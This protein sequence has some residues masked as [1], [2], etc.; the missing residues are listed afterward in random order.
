[1]SV[2]SSSEKTQATKVLDFWKIAAIVILLLAI[3]TRFYALGDRAVSHDE[4][5]HAK[6]SWNLYTGQGFRHDPLMHGPLLFEVTA[7]LYALFGVSDFTARIYAAALGVALV[8][9]PWLFQK[10]LG[11]RGALFAS[12]MLLIS[13]AITYY[14][15][16]TR[17]D[18][19]V[20]LWSTLLLWT[21]LQYL[22]T[23][24]T[25]WLY[26]M[27]A[28]FPLMYASKENAYIYTAIF[29]VLLALPFLWQVMRTRWA[30]P[31]FSAVLAVVVIIAL[32][33]G[34]GFIVSLT[35]AQVSEVEDTG[36][37]SISNI[38]IPGWGRLALGMA[39]L[40]ALSAVPVIYYGVGAESL[41]YLRLFDVLMTLGT[42]TLPLGSAFLMKFV[43]G[44]D[45][46][47]FYPA[48]M[49]LKFGAIPLQMTLAALVTFVLVVA[50]SVALGLW[51]DIK[52]WP[53]IALIHYG[54]FITLFS[55]FFTYG[56]GVMTGQIGALAYWIAQQTVDRGK[57]PWYYYAVIGPL[58]EYM[59]LL[60]SI[61]AGIWGFVR[62]VLK[63][64][65]SPS[66]S[67]KK[68]DTP[69]PLNLDL[70][71]PLFLAGWAAMSWVAYSYAGEKMPW[72]FVHIALPHV[73]LAA[74][75]LGQWLQ[76]LEW[77]DIAQ[78]GWLLLVT[79]PLLWKALQ[80]F[81]KAVNSSEQVLNIGSDAAGG[82]TLA[83]LEPLVGVL[84]ALGGVILLSALLLW[85]IDKIGP[86][87]TLRLTLLTA[88]G[89]LA[90][91]TVRT[92]FM[93][94]FINDEL[95]TEFMVYAHATPD[96][97]VVLA[98]IEDISWRTTGTANEIKVA[99]G[100]E[101][102]WPF[103]WYMATRYPNSYYY[104]D[105]PEAERLLECPVIIAGK[106]QWGVVEA[107]LGADYVAYN[108]KYI[109]WPIEDYKDLT[110][111][112]IRG[113]LDDPQM[114][115]A[116]ADIIRNRDYRA[117]A[118]LTNPQNPFTLQTWPNRLD[119]H[120]YVRRDLVQQIWSYST[121]E[122]TA[123]R[124][125]VL[126]TYAASERELPLIFK[127]HLS[128]AA[129]RGIAIAPDGTFYIADT[130]QHSIWR[131]SPK[132]ELLNTWGEY[133][134]APGQFNEPWDV[135]VDP[136][137]NVYVADTWNH[138]IQKFTA[139]GEFVLSWGRLGQVQAYDPAGNGLFYGPRGIAVGPNGAIYVADTGNHRVQVFNSDGVFLREFGGFGSLPNQMNEPVGIAVNT[140]G[141]VFVADTW[142]RRVQA[143]S[144]ESIY[145]RE[146]SVPL[147]S[148]NPAE[149]PFL[150][151]TDQVMVVGAPTQGRVLAFDYAGN[152]LWN[153]HDPED[154]PFP[155]GLAF[156]DNILYVVDGNTGDLIG[157]RTE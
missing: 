91:W 26:G 103:Y 90:V 116:L 40:F 70:F 156:F 150:A 96:V 22:D 65:S 137:G 124:A 16:Y 114:R 128:N 82:L 151:V 15:R 119:M 127:A 92:M 38:T 107:I 99:Y 138:R 37:T 33:A 41:R 140:V 53:I 139:E 115:A 149:K 5:T 25:R 63:L 117:Y 31:K 130:A 19:P 142:N 153:L 72:L 154:L 14:A 111:E 55:T 50:L 66:A 135:A 76:K 77:Q 87:R 34:G 51:W 39:F 78:R 131:L 27:A 18:T 102:A 61:P 74:W 125:E 132:G 157:Y 69:K 64:A 108:Y 143:F 58:Y 13:P 95:A 152:L 146:W 24:R 59:P 29:L 101:G 141:E 12:I 83:G 126:D 60:L 3:V 93:L 113:A 147:W 54:I 86:R 43:A 100:Q 67:S 45:M 17:H 89:T 109:W 62:P 42:L 105:A 47:L 88:C 52:R 94:N 11:K 145:R 80:A 136:D 73:L 7:L 1:M 36:N 122:T 20:M 133:G 123:S 35:G 46:S 71:F 155:E 57:Q 2:P 28:F 85:T 4:M 121:D 81:G 118:Q 97:K 48:L 10:W 49:N 148:G 144:P 110:W 129:G 75:G 112:R 98:Q 21:V 32:L 56:W 23:G 134:V 120:L 9:T 8:M 68:Q 30:R 84:C 106:P 44:V 104:G 6:F 79:L